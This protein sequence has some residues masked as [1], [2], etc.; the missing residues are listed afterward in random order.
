MNR[1][2]K[3]I[4]KKI[5]LLERAYYFFTIPFK[6]RTERSLLKGKSFHSINAKSIL[7]FSMNKAATQYV[8]NVLETIAL[9]NEMVPAKFNEYAMTCDLPFF[10]QLSMEEMKKYKHVFKSHGFLYTVFSEMF[11]DVVDFKKYNIVFS[12]RD[13]RD[14]LVSNYYSSAFSH[15]LPP[16]SGNKRKDFIKMREWVKS[17]EI[18]EYVLAECDRVYNVF[19]KYKTDLV[20]KHHHVAILKYETMVSDYSKWLATLSSKTEMNLSE[21]LK[22]QLTK[23]FH[24]NRSKKEDIN[25]HTRKGVAGDYLEKLKPETI[26]IL[27][28]KFQNL[29]EFYGYEL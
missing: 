29:L 24:K 5:P 12:I 13:P 15:S 1:S 21:N 28:D 9:E 20:E 17:V 8:K 26:K 10:H 23:S 6:F 19:D 18:D 3:E 11:Y 16:I 22:N 14:I 2:V 7:H 25:S 27:N 4:L